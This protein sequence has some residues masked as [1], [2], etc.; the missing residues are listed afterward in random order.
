M[1]FSSRILRIR[2]VFMLFVAC[3]FS[4]QQTKS[5]S[6]AASSFSFH[7]F[8]NLEYICKQKRLN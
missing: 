5:P 2:V 1:A 3:F 4:L 6:M 8:L 7:I